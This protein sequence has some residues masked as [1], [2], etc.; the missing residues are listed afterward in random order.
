MKKYT[1]DLGLGIVETKP[2]ELTNELGFITIFDTGQSGKM[3]GL[4]TKLDDLP[5]IENEDN[6][7]GK[8]TVISKNKGAMHACDHDG[9][10]TTS[11]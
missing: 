11:V 5:V 9:H 1:T 7:A 6:L 10:M 8:R 2:T 4:R 3:L